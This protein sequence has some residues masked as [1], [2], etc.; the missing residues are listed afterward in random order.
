MVS[1]VE[2]LFNAKVI[3]NE[4]RKI[5]TVG[6]VYLDNVTGQPSWIAVK[7]GLFGLKETFVPLR[8]A[9]IS[10]EAVQVPYPVDTVKDAPRVDPDQPMDPAQE[11]TLYHYY[12]L[13]FEKIVT[14]IPAG[15]NAVFA[16]RSEPG[17]GN[18]E[19]TPAAPQPEQTPSEQTPS[20]VSDAD[21]QP[22]A[23]GE[24]GNPLP[25]DQSSEQEDNDEESLSANE[26]SVTTDTASANE[27]AASADIDAQVHPR[28]AQA[29]DDS[30]SPLGSLF[31]R[32]GITSASAA[33][34]RYGTKVYASDSGLDNTPAP[35]ESPVTCEPGDTPASQPSPA[36]PIPDEEP[37]SQAAPAD[38]ESSDAPASPTPQES[39]ADPEPSEQPSDQPSARPD[40][41]ALKAVDLY[42]RVY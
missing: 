14:E 12:E 8:N 30:P 3:D 7:T 24:A 39:P 15:E 35:Q 33:S 37:A 2:Q 4:G 1:Q 34:F 26:A 38:P 6:Q 40:L 25:F 18:D 27:E 22:G 11:S 19:P 16:D 28:R 36:D 29:D 23:D 5:G 41:S 10:D 9:E 20:E 32:A 13:A 31:D 42:S 17:I 21:A